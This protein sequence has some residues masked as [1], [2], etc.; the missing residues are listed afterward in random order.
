MSCVL[1]SLLASKDIALFCDLVGAPYSPTTSANVKRRGPVFNTGGISDFTAT[2][3]H[4]R[5]IFWTSLRIRAIIPFALSIGAYA[6]FKI[7][8][9]N[10]ETSYS[11]KSP[12]R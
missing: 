4:K 7:S 5:A 9:L 12:Y 2:T 10:W 11:E 1:P 8:S 6:T 3:S